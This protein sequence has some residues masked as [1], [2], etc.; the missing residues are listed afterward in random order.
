MLYGLKVSQ[1]QTQRPTDACTLFV[2]FFGLLHSHKLPLLFGGCPVNDKH[3]IVSRP[4][5]S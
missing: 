4:S 5:D 1:A 2:V 3:D